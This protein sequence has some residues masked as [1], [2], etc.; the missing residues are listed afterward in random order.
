VK[1]VGDVTGG[2]RRPFRPG[3]AP[4]ELVGGQHL[5]VLTQALEVGRALGRG[6]LLREDARREQGDGDEEA[7]RFLVAHETTS[8]SAQAGQSRLR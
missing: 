8:V 6:L 4:P 2:L 3:L 1:R 5:D 7:E